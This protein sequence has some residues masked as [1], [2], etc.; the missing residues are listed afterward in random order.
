MQSDMRPSI[1]RRGIGLDAMRKASV[2]QVTL[3]HLVSNIDIERV[4]SNL[5]ENLIDFGTCGLGI[6]VQSSL[7]LGEHA[8][9][10]S[11]T[12]GTHAAAGR[13]D[14]NVQ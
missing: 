13:T 8:S 6:W 4:K 1:K 11:D 5:F 9:R 3:D 12:W 10:L 2:A 14:L 7:H